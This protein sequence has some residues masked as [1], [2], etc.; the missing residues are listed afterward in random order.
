[1]PQIIAGIV[2]AVGAGVGQM[3]SVGGNL[4]R[5]LW[6]G[7][8]GLAGWLWDRVSSWCSNLWD[9]ILGFFGIHSPSTEM[10]WVGQMLTKGLAGGIEDS[11]KQAV[12]AATAMA[13]DVMDSFTELATGVDVPVGLNSDALEIPNLQPATASGRS[14]G[15]SAAPVGGV[16]VRGLVEQTARSL[17]AGLDI[18][19]VLDD[20]TLVGKLTPSIDKQLGLRS[21]RNSSLL[22]GVYA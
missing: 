18:R 5:G 21:R 4:V 13:A 22:G 15:G 12:N 8:Q 2:G 16:D 19:V 1:M 9:G 11:G 7:I 14:V 10:A 3:V 17:L 20:G 6:T